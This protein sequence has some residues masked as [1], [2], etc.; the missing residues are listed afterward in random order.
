MHLSREAARFTRH[1]M[2][3]VVRHWVPMSLF[4]LFLLGHENDCYILP[5]I[6]LGGSGELHA[7]DD[8][9]R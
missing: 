8:R 9:G 3:S 2:A 5:W 7:W 6:V 1:R 4:F